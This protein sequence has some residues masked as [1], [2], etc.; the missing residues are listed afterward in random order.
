MEKVPKMFNLV[1]TLN[2][3]EHVK[4][5][6]ARE[7]LAS[8]FLMSLDNRAGSKQNDR[9]GSRYPNAKPTLLLLS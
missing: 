3:N 4:H 1:A 8:L 6:K 2:Q 5:K 7:I 9:P